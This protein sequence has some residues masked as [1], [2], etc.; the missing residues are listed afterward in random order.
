MEPKRTE[1]IKDTVY[2]NIQMPMLIEVYPAPAYGTE[3]YFA[4]NVFNS[5]LS[6][7]NSARL[8]KQIVDTKKTGL[9]AGGGVMPFEHPGVFMIQG[10]PNGVDLSVLEADIDAEVYGLLENGMSDEEFQKVMNMVEMSEATSNTTI[11][12]VAESLATAYTYLKNTN[13][14][15]ETMEQYSKLTKEK[16]LEV[17]RKYID[18]AQKI[19]I[20][21]L[22]KQN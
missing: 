21:Y 5:I 9:M 22:P 17:A 16:V 12:G 11:E 14:V 8:Q 13:F 18:P 2:D 19:S 4:M 15:N 1:P 7:G 3:D 6:A 10:I 20:Y